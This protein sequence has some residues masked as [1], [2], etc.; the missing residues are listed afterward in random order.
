MMRLA[1]ALSA[2]TAYQNPAA[3]WCSRGS[4]F[5][6]GHFSDHCFSFY[7][8][9]SFLPGGVDDVDDIHS[10]LRPAHANV[11]HTRS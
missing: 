9:P 8:H 1:A 3:L 5:N 10:T 6:G 11:C 2:A 4:A 7:P